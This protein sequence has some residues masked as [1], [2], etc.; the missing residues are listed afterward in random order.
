MSSGMRDRVGVAELNG[1]VIGEAAQVGAVATH[2]SLIS[3]Q[4]GG[5]EEVLLA[6]A[7][8]R[9]E[10]CRWGTGRDAMVPHGR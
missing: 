7:Q 8:D 2:G 6:Y 3:L 9:L 4:G 10:R 1:V 5:A